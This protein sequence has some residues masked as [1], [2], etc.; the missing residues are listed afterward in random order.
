MKSKIAVVGTGYWGK[1]LVRNFHELGHL[2]MICDSNELILQGYEEKYP[3]IRL[4]LNYSEVLEDKEINAV[5]LA[6]PAVT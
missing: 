6:T 2:A 4:Q 3:G 5:V 1:N